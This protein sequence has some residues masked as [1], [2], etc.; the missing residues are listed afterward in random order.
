MIFFLKKTWLPF[1]VLLVAVVLPVFISIEVLYWVFLPLIFFVWVFVYYRLEKDQEMLDETLDDDNLQIAIDKYISG[2]NDCVEQEVQFFQT[3]LLQL[4]TVVAD[5]V[6]TMSG[7]FNGLHS[8]TAEQSGVVHSLMSELGGNLDA[9]GLNFTKFA[10]ETDNVLKFFVDHIL[11]ISKQSMQMVGVINDVGEHMSKVE[12]LLTDVQGIADQTNLLA[13]NAAIEA[14]RAGEAGRGFA[15]VAD[16]VR[17]LS[18]NSDK[19][20]E[21]I[22]VVVNASKKN[23]TL[24][25]DMIEAMASKDMNVAISSK[26]NINT[27]MQAITKMNDS[28]ALK[29]AEVSGIS[30]QI[31]DSVGHAVRGLQ[32]EDMTR[33]RADYLLLNTQHFQAVSDE[34]GIGLGAFKTGS[35]STWVNELE[36]GV[37]RL[38]EMRQQWGMTEKKVV[39]QESMDEGDIELF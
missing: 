30:D 2:V 11:L 13:L 6:N 22:R 21:E 27:M 31:E 17:N 4:K 36:E 23:I 3:E 35:G 32:F 8:L 19:F 20:S 9:E 33:Q 15:V 10:E 28:I 14:A 26:S 39:S 25:Q 38:N 34:L 24:A 5:A 7:S 1:V 16:E 37:V 18:R 29:I 12:K